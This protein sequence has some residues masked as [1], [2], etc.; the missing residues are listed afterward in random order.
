LSR[1]TKTGES[2][3]PTTRVYTSLKV[4]YVLFNDSDHARFLKSNT[5]SSSSCN[6]VPYQVQGCSVIR[7][8]PSIPVFRKIA[9][10]A[11]QAYET[12]EKD[13]EMFEREMLASEYLASGACQSVDAPHQGSKSCGMC[14]PRRIRRRARR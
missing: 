12:D 9:F 5:E 8:A 10:K 7:W 13:K 3:H 11:D 4:N 14:Y 1:C 2:F 6:C